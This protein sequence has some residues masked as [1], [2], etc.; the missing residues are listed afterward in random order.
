MKA[1]ASKSITYFQKRLVKWFRKEARLPPWRE[2]SDPYKIWISEIMCQ[3]TGVQTVVPYYLRF[4]KK[5]PNIQALAAS[6]EED[7]LKLWE[8]LGYYSRARNL[9]KA[10]QLVM[11]E[12]NGK[13]PQTREEILKLPG[14]GEYSAGAILSIA[15]QIATPAL[16]GNLIRVYSRHYGFT[17]AVNQPSALKKL[18]KVAAEHSVLKAQDIRDFTE[19]M[20][21]LGATICR[22][23]NAQCEI[24]PLTRTCVS[25]ARGWQNELPK[26]R[27]SRKREKYV[28]H[29]FLMRKGSKVALLPRGADSKYPDFYRLPFSIQKNTDEPKVFHSKWKYS[30]THRDFRV[31]VLEKSLPKTLQKKLIWAS[32]AEILSFVF[33]AIDRRILKNL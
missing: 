16:D 10:A 19:G 20:M 26:K 5:F 15:H 17:E 1:V 18:W 24:C 9:R 23:K 32:K 29:I 2:T 6:Q 21:D 28:E 8:G 25:Y 31:Y 7:V 3:Q 13:L 27:Q 14:V 11:S 12:F 33:P 22:P 4:L 30:V